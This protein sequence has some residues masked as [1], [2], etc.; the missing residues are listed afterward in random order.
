MSPARRFRRWPRLLVVVTCLIV[1]LLAFSV[2]SGQCF[3]AAPGA[4]A[5]S[6]TSGPAI[7]WPAAWLLVVIGAV[8]FVL[9][10]IRLVRP[11]RGAR[12]GD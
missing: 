8:G 12:G 1:P 2:W 11:E 4:G 10:A 9:G 7:G 3:D 6:C 5:S